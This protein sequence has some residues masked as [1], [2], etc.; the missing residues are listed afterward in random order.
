MTAPDAR[1][2]PTRPIIGVGAVVMK[3]S[4]ILL[5]RRGKPPKA[6]EWSLPGGAQELGETTR[7][8]AVREIKEETGLEVDLLDLLDVIDFIDR[9][10]DGTI[11]YHY[12]LVDY[13]A[14]PVAGSL[15]AGSDAHDARF[16]PL[17]EAL[18]LPLW[19]ET[20]RVIRLAGER[21]EKK[22][23]DRYQ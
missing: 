20:R 19:E 13:L 16:F 17:D 7:E 8:A 3:G 2:K 11:R 14:V 15:R 10:E 1:E 22:N 18:S 5:I 21:H 12:S 23:K 6:G 4:E 9:A